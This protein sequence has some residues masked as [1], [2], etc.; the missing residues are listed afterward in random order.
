MVVTHSPRQ[1]TGAAVLAAALLLVAACDESPTRPSE[2]QGQTWR[3]VSLQ[4][5]GAA[6]IAVADP[7]RYTIRFVDAGRVNARSDCNTCGGGYSM[8]GASVSIGALA[9]TRVFC[10]AAS[11]DAEY[12]RALESARSLARSGDELIVQCDGVA[13]RFRM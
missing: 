9:C 1:L 11:L 7:S 5:A 4:R 8:T 13:L 10:G 6:P 3:L 12:T 2:I